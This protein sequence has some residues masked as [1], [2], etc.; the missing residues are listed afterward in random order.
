M[1]LTLELN[2]GLTGRSPW[3]SHLNLESDSHCVCTVSGPGL[4]SK[5]VILILQRGR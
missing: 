5:I 2:P 3:S 1:H 4:R